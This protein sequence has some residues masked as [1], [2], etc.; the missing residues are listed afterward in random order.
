M[1][2][3]LNVFVLTSKASAYIKLRILSRGTKNERSKKQKCERHLNE[4]LHNFLAYKN[5]S[6]LFARGLWVRVEMCQAFD[7]LRDNNVATSS[8][9]PVL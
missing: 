8:F 5:H 7:A 2:T 6:S 1:Q 9:R 4:C 3:R